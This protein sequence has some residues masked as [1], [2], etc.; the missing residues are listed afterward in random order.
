MHVFLQRMTCWMGKRSLQ[1]S[2]DVER[3]FAI[4]I[5]ESWHA[6]VKVFNLPFLNLKIR[7]PAMG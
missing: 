5:A 6:I 2:S 4:F 1:P 3:R 7:Y